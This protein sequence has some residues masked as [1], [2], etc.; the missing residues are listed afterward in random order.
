ML[1]RDKIGLRIAA[2][3]T[4]QLQKFDVSLEA[5]TVQLDEIRKHALEEGKYSAAVS[6]TMLIARLHGFDRQ[7]TQVAVRYE[8][9][10]Q[11]RTVIL[12]SLL[13]V[14]RYKGV[15]PRWLEYLPYNVRA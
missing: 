8:S 9:T 1:H 15:L 5:L 3:R 12:Q 13:A 11:E 7:H 10:P 14:Q 6:A 2:L 4:R